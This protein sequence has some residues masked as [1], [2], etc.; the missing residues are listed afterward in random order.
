M[1]RLQRANWG[2]A[3]RSA[4]HRDETRLWQ[5]PLGGLCKIIAL[6]GDGFPKFS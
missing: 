3:R 1:G 2:M 4:V 5:H 6:L